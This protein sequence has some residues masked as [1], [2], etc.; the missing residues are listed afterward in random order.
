MSPLDSWTR[1]THTADGIS[2]DTYRK[3]TGPG[4]IVIHEIPGM[5]AEVIAFGEEVV[6]AGYTVVMPHLFGEA[7]GAMSLGAVA[8]VFPRLCVNKEFTKIALN[9]TTPIATWLR[10]LAA[11]LHDELGGPG[12]GALGMC[13]TGGYAL[14]MMV[15][16][17]VAAPVLCQPSTPL[18]LGRQR[19][20]DV[21]LS[22]EDLA[23]V[24]RRAAAGC[25]VLGLR[26]RDDKATGTRFET[27]REELGEQFLSVEFGGKG[28]SVVTEHRQQEAV[29][30]I[31]AF[32]DERLH[33]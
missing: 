21:N 23:I 5:T 24:R 10:T 16:S 26:Y 27:L 7:G 20:A 28:H 3:G 25:A 19:A 8:K 31:L 15:D 22:P 6:A 30:R 2:H 4:V 12:V 29:D 14:A 33:H 1:A 11:G 9:E 18:P 13:F 17:S 32:F